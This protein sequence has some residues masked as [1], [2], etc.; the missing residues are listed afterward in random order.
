MSA[1]LQNI[2]ETLQVCVYIR[3]RVDEGIAHSGLSSQ[4]YNELGFLARK[5]LNHTK[6]IFYT[7]LLEAETWVTSKARQASFFKRRVVVII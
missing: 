7:E 6:A 1:A 5:Q 4:V 2:S 3:V